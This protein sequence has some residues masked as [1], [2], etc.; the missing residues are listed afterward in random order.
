MSARLARYLSTTASICAGA[1]LFVATASPAGQAVGG[2]GAGVPGLG[3]G[4]RGGGRGIQPARDGSSVPAVGTGGISG[5]VILGGTGSP[6]R[7]ARVTLSGAELRGTRNVTTDEYGRF[8]FQMLPAGRFTMTA[9]KAGFVNVAYGAKRP[10]RPGTPIQLEDGQRLE[11]LS[12]V[13][14][15]GGVITGV[16][17]D[18]TGEPA[19]ST[20]V[21]AMRSV[22]RTGER[23]LAYAGQD[24]TDDRGIYRIFGLQPGDYV[25]T[26]IP[27]NM[28]PATNVRQII[29]SQAAALQDTLGQPGGRAG[30]AGF[31]LEN[32]QA[33]ASSPAALQAI[34]DLAAVQA[35]AIE[36]DQPVAY[37]PVYYPGTTSPSGATT[38]TLGTSEERGGVDFQ[39]QLVSTAL[40]QGQVVSPDGVLPSALQVQLAPADQTGLPGG[41]GM[42]MSRPEGNGQFTFRDVTP[43]QYRLQAR[44]VVRK[45]DASGNT[46]TGRRGGRGPVPP[47]QI[48][49]VLWA[50]ADVAISGQDVTNLQLLLQPGMTV[51]GRVEF[52]GVGA[53]APADLTGLRLTLA[54]RGPS[55]PGGGNPPPAVVDEFGRFT[56]RGV[57][58]GHYGVTG[59]VG[60][61]G[62]RGGGG[63][64][65]SS[66]WRLASAIVDG[67]DVLDFPLEIGPNQ[68]VEGAVLTFTDQGQELSGRIQDAAGRPTADFT[69]IVF[70]S[71]S[72]YWLPQARRIAS[73]RPGTD[74]SFVLR[75]LPVGDYRL[76]A[77]TDVEPGEWY[78]PDFLA[79]LAGVSLPIT[80]RDGEKR[81][82]DIKVAN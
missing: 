53:Q 73:T 40:V 63:A 68:N 37:A 61:G 8:V 79:Q 72:R 30:Q 31:V 44:G 6:V 10:G 4:Q 14:P 45:P 67:R 49:Q 46:P 58:P 75:N 56:L 24:Q 43:G 7:R 15:R 12:I 50:A 9:S 77:V 76:T 80:L 54:T 57:A 51:T 13:L 11:K 23:S 1:V 18:E 27:R 60:Q 42:A 52:R 41:M 29:Q 35:G 36:A 81:V 3:G 70:P 5:A 69:I 66:T 2:R 34:A 71:D 19:P 26:A 25:L 47:N 20:Q 55:T 48:A 38:V 28:N 17:V 16:V 33:F 78:D 62:G 32:L 22:M 74:G 39:L 65:G 64:A 59:S 82:Q 21:R